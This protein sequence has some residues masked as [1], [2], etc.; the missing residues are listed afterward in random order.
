MDKRFIHFMTGLKIREL[1]FDHQVDVII[2]K[3]ERE[4]WIQSKLFYWLKWEILPVEEILKRVKSFVTIDSRQL[5]FAGLESVKIPQR[6]Y[7]S[8]LGYNLNIRLNPEDSSF[9]NSILST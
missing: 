8:G 5:P 2:Y 4:I 7:G 6:R 3:K 1:R 9:I